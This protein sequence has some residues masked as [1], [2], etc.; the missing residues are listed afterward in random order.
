MCDTKISGATPDEMKANGMVHIEEAHPDMAASIK[1]MAADDPKMVE[2]QEKF[3]KT[4]AD[5]PEE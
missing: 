4:W 5:T 1:S 2:W 3:M